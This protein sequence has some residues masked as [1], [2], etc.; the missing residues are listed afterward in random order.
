MQSISVFP[1]IAKFPDFR[2]KNAVLA[3]GV[4]HMIHEFFGSSLGKVELCQF[5]SLPISPFVSSLEKAYH[6]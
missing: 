2:W 1:D 6:E 5:S 4:Y 3:E